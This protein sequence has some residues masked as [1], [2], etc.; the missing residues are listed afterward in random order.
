[1]N[2][3]TFLPIIILSIGLL[4]GCALPVSEQVTTK[5]VKSKPLKSKPLKIRQQIEAHFSQLA[6]DNEVKVLSSERR[7]DGMTELYIA[8]EPI[9]TASGVTQ[10]TQIFALYNLPKVPLLTATGKIP[11]MVLVHGGGG[12]AFK[13][14]VEKWNEAGFAAISIAVEGQTDIPVD[15]LQSAKVKDTLRWQKHQSS[16]PSRQGIYADFDKPLDEQWMFHAVSAVIRAKHFLA[17]QVDIDKQHIGLTGISWGGVITSTVLGFDNSFD[18]SIPIYGCGFLDSMQNQYQSALIANAAYKDIWEPGH[19]IANYLQPSLW[20]TWR[21]DKHFALDAQA[22]SYAQL[23]GDYS[24]SIKPG[25]RHGHRPGWNQ[26][27]SYFFAKHV[28]RQGHVWAKSLAVKKLESGQVQAEFLVNLAENDYQ[29]TKATIHYT[30]DKGH[31][32]S[33]KWLQTDA[34][35]VT[36]KTQPGRIIVTSGVVMPNDVQHWFVNLA[37]R[38]HEED[39]IF[40]VSSTLYSD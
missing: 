12:T 7:E 24:V 40:T 38:I 39:Q 11:A 23:T 19:R 21:D 30:K 9:T 17:S 2:K 34:S 3:F 25:I 33:A 16:G 14:W 22:R 10:P 20:L 5:P 1:M 15:D 32:G 31:T 26:A 35:V 13:E 6:A 4:N 37:V 28:V 29:I 8:G 18:F 27:E 36:S